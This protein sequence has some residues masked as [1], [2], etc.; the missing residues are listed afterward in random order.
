MSLAGFMLWH[1]DF[2]ERAGMRSIARDLLLKNEAEEPAGPAT[3]CQITM[4]TGAETFHPARLEMMGIKEKPFGCGFRRGWRPAPNGPLPNRDI[5][6][7]LDA[8]T[9]GSVRRQDAFLVE[10]AAR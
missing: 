7:S 8:R 5:A 10:S 3:A 2:L 4:G 9:G 6:E 1:I